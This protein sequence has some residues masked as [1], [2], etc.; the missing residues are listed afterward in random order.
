MPASLPRPSLLAPSH[1]SGFSLAF[2]GPRD[3]YFMRQHELEREAA[4]QRGL[5]D[6]FDYHQAERV[7]TNVLVGLLC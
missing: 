6:Y 1:G 5:S 3:S 2:A 4:Y 7:S